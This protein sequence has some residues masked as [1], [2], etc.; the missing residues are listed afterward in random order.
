MLCIGGFLAITLTFLN[1]TVNMRQGK[2]GNIIVFF[3]TALLWILI[4]LNISIRIQNKCVVKMLEYVGRNSMSFVCLN[5]MIIL[6]IIRLP[7]WNSIVRHESIVQIF[8]LPFII[9]INCALNE[10]LSNGRLRFLFG[11]QARMKE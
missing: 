1:S 11:K 6:F 9:V 5:Q 8:A 3:I 2:Y 7:D 4:F 10:L